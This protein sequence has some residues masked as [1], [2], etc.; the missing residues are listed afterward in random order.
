MPNS[1][2]STPKSTG[3]AP[4]KSVPSTDS[5]TKKQS[6][7]KKVNSVTLSS[8]YRTSVKKLMKQIS[9]DGSIKLTDK[10]LHII[11][12]IAYSLTCDLA[13]LVCSLCN[14]V[15]RGTI[16]GDDIITAATLSYPGEIRTNSVKDMMAAI[17][18]NQNKAARK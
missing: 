11:V 4:I 16:I 14:K 17:S 6:I 2:M 1:S 10:G 3:K 8:Q 18:K 5:Q 12:E 15:Q 7:K 9:Q 13:E